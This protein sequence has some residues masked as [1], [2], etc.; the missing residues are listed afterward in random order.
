MT[1]LYLQNAEKRLRSDC[2]EKIKVVILHMN[3]ANF[4]SSGMDSSNSQ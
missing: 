1:I 4:R 3:V 2:I